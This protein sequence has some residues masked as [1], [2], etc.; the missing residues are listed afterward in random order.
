M[1]IRKH[2]AANNSLPKADLTFGDL[3]HLARPGLPAH[4]ALVAHDAR[5][6][7]DGPGTASSTRDGRGVAGRIVGPAQ[8][9]LL[10]CHFGRGR[11][12]VSN[13]GGF[14][15]HWAGVGLGSRPSV[16]GCGG[17]AVGVIRPALRF[18]AS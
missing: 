12:L 9:R 13:I 6:P 1:L 10:G 16:T 17:P 4:F 7:L 2:I 11:A 8:R 3:H 15:S 5:R 18:S 14:K